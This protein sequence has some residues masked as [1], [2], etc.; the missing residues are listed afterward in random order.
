MCQ[1]VG[2]RLGTPS[3]KGI[4]EISNSLAEH[5]LNAKGVAQQE[6]SNSE[7]GVQEAD[8]GGSEWGGGLVDLA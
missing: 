6:P 2:N 1:A 3:P 7:G 4:I 5:T 8:H